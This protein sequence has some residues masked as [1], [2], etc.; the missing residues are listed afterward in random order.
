MQHLHVATHLSCNRRP[1]L[2]R[3]VGSGLAIQGIELLRALVFVGVF[4]CQKRHVSLTQNQPQDP[5]S[6]IQTY[7]GSHGLRES[8]DIK[9]GQ[10]CFCQKPFRNCGRVQKTPALHVRSRRGWKKV[11]ATG[12]HLQHCAGQLRFSDEA[13][14]PQSAPAPSTSSTAIPPRQGSA[15]SGCGAGRK[16]VGCSG[17]C[18][19]AMR[20]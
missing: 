11:C 4:C 7:A 10:R 14:A 9:E 6:G 19:R 12:A 17:R 20:K 8:D 15:S 3:Q 18:P 1:W 16:S 5:G 2:R 13:P